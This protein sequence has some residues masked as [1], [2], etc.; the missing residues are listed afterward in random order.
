MAQS[1]DSDGVSRKK[2]TLDIN[3]QV[4][5]L[6]TDSSP[7]RVEAVGQLVS[8]LVEEISLQTKAPASQKTVLMALIKLAD[9]HIDLQARHD[10]LRAEAA[11]AS[12][13]AI[14]ALDTALKGRT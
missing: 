13:E 7:E 6:W 11:S 14:T 8:R 3:G 12:V 9:K 2:V 10:A 4:I 1:R 5:H